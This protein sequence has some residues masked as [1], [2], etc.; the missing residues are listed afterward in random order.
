MWGGALSQGSGGMRG[1]REE[2]RSAPAAQRFGCSLSAAPGARPR[3]LARGGALVAERLPIDERF[4]LKVARLQERCARSCSC[5]LHGRIRRCPMAMCLL[6]ACRP[7]LRSAALWCA[8]WNSLSTA[9]PTI[10]W[11]LVVSS[12]CFS[13]AAHLGSLAAATIRRSAASSRNTFVQYETAVALARGVL[14]P[15][16]AA[17]EGG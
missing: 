10:I 2:R 15:P 6:T 16:A 13:P 7:S 5:V 4:D 12:P 1:S 17:P 9:R 3:H 8:A 11:S 14:A